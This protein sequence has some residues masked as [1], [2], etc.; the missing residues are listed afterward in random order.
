MPPIVTVWA[1]AVNTLCEGW[2][3]GTVTEDETDHA[4]VYPIRTAAEQELADLI[5]DRLTQFIEDADSY[6]DIEAALDCGYEV[7]EAAMRDDGTV[8][9]DGEEKG[10]APPSIRLALTKPSS[11]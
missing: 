1:V 11:H 6:G 9:I 2:S 5:R 10:M 8:L 4:D 3:I 7:I